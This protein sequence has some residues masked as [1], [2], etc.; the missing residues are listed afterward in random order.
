VGKLIQL[1]LFFT[2]FPRNHQMRSRKV[3]CLID[4]E[5]SFAEDHFYPAFP[6]SKNIAGKRGTGSFLSCFRG[7]LPY[8]R[9]SSAR[10]A[11]PQQPTWKVV[12]RYPVHQPALVLVG[13]AADVKRPHVL[14]KLFVYGAFV[15]EHLAV[16]RSEHRN[17]GDWSTNRHSAQSVGFSQSEPTRLAYV[18][19]CV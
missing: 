10:L 8:H 4:A 19:S 13:E 7:H 12:G 1:C 18:L 5:W 9:Q 11:Q 2:S 17:V 3:V 14:D 15:L 6:W 16:G